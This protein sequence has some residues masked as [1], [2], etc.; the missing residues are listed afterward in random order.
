[1]NRTE[2]EQLRL[3]LHQGAERAARAYAAVP[4]R[5]VTG[6]ERA[7]A[8]HEARASGVSVS[9]DGGYDEAERVQVCFHPFDEEPVFTAQWV[10]AAWHAKFGSPEHRDL[11]GS[12]MGLG[13]DRAFFGDLVAQ[14]ARAYVYT[15]PEIAARLPME[16]QQAGRITLTVHTLDEK[17]AL[18]LP[19]GEQ[20]HDTVASPRLDSILA[21]GMRCSRSKAC[22]LI[23]QGLVMVEHL[24]EERTDRVL[25]AGML[26]SIRGFGR[27]RL[28]DIGEPTRKDR[29]PVTLEVFGKR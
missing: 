27:I 14:E 13:M 28:I 23:R 22:D 26:L 1:M 19:R 16:W 20:L 4:G 24:P 9:F 8:V 2:Q 6:E 3:R 17:P 12:L 25:S 7:L 10:E 5:F 21:S 29:L 11:L 15:L 18:I